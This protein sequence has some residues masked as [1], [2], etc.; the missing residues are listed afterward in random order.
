M[1]WIYRLTLAE[2]TNAKTLQSDWDDVTPGSGSVENPNGGVQV[3]GTRAVIIST[4]HNSDYQNMADKSYVVSISERCE[5]NSEKVYH[6]MTDEVR[7]PHP[8]DLIG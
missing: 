4:R 5:I 3:F 7:D 6:L 1:P 8:C 2:Y